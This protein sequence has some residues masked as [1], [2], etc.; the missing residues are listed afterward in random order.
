M[1][2]PGQ[3]WWSPLRNVVILAMA[4]VGSACSGLP[5]YE[6]TSPPNLG[7]NVKVSRGGP[8]SISARGVTNFGVFLHI[9]AINPACAG[10][11]LGSVKIDS[12]PAK[13]GIPADQL[14]YLTFE[15]S[16]HNFLT[17]GSGGTS[18]SSLLTARKGFQY[19]IDVEYTDDM[20]SVNMFERGPAN[21]ARRQVEHRSLRTCSAQS[22]PKGR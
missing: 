20:Y 19:E 4:V 15:F 6:S 7:V 3:S 17:R 16:G 5:T 2:Q 9:N 12:S 21:G 8:L 13:I 1:K 11:Y 14:V 22:K 10:A 18:W